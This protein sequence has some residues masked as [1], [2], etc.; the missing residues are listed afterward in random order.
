MCCKEFMKYFFGID[1]GASGAVAILTEEGHF[2]KVFDMPVLEMKVGKAIKRRVSADLLAHEVSLYPNAIAM[3]EQ[4]SA[5]PGQG[6]SSMFAFGESYGIVKGVFAAFKIPAHLVTPNKWKKAME[7]N[8]SK[9]GSRAKA[10]QM[11]PEQAA[12]FKRVKDDGR[13]EACLLAEFGRRNN[14]W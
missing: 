4:V 3:L 1:P 12:M 11:W 9:D 13:A 14:P 6:V 5:M 7:L 8:A 10:I 2:V